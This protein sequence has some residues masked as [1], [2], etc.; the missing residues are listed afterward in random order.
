MLGIITAAIG[1]IAAAATTVVNTL[2]VVGLAVQGLRTIGN[3]LMSLGKALGLIKPETKMEDLGD[4]ALQSGYSP[5][6]YDSYAEYVKAVEDY[7]LDP[8]KSKLTTEEEKIKK[9]MELAAGVTI[10]KYDEF[11]IQ[12]FCVEAGQNP[13]YFTDARMGEIAKLMEEDGQY[14][15]DILNYVNGSEKNE[16][17]IQGMIDTLVG[18]EKSVDPLISDKDALKNVLQVR[19]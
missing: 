18:V 19:K 13:E 15:S 11:P 16:F 6:D 4:K 10:E 14:V 7:D 5:E 17:K 3:V 8:E 2:A 1:A 9:G 12:E